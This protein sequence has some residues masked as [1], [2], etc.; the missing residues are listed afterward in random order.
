MNDNTH[1][2]D[3][4]CTNSLRSDRWRVDDLISDRTVLL[5]RE[6]ATFCGVSSWQIMALF[7]CGCFD[8]AFLYFTPFRLCTSQPVMYLQY[9]GKS[10]TYYHQTP[11]RLGPTL[12]LRKVYVWLMLHVSQRTTLA[13]RFGMY[14]TTYGTADM[15]NGN[16]R[17][18]IVD[19]NTNPNP[20]RSDRV[21]SLC[22]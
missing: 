2:E 15:F 9:P 20:I 18:M 1:L 10:S 14:V 17:C 13:I 11:T 19:S 21:G 12:P 8:A 6:R 22:S 3:W 5:Q 16:K 4:N 7:S